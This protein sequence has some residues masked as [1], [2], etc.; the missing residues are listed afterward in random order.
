MKALMG[1]QRREHFTPKRSPQGRLHREGNT[2]QYHKNQV[3]V[4]HTQGV[5]REN[6][7][8]RSCMYKGTDRQDSMKSE[9]S[10]ATLKQGQ[11]A[12]KSGRSLGGWPP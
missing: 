1:L 2:E 4:C 11:W 8:S 9:S 5:G 10:W 12:M 6:P 3:G 7:E